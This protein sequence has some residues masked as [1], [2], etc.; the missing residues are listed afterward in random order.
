[1]I[2]HIY[3]IVSLS[4]IGDMIAVRFEP[5]QTAKNKFISV[6]AFSSFIFKILDKVLNCSRCMSFWLSLI[7]TKD[8]LAAALAGLLGFLINHLH[9]RIN[10]WYE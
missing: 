1:M 2:E 3:L 5:I 7:V 8:I 4:V 10:S 6:F 9:D